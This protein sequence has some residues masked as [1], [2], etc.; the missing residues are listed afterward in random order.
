MREQVNFNKLVGRRGDEYY[1]CDYIFNQGSFK[2][3]T[4]TVLRPI[5]KDEYDERTDRSNLIDYLEEP[6]KE[7]VAAGQTTEGLGEWAEYAIDVD[8]V[9]HCAGFDPSGEE[10]YPQLRAIGLTEEEYPAIECTGG[11]RSFSHDQQFDE[12]FDAELLEKIRR[13]ETPGAVVL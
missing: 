3:A 12:V 8:G 6:W 4:A 7:A 9:E 1:F 11:G 2:G 13:V 10:L 5:P